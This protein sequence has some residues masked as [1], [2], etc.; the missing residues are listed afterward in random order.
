MMCVQV[1]DGVTQV[2]VMEGRS[3]IEHYVSRPSDDVGQI[4]GNIY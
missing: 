2:A 4:H 3:L 1:R